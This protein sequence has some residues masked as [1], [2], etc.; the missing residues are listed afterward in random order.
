MSKKFTQMCFSY[1]VDVQRFHDTLY[2]VCFFS[3]SYL[4]CSTLIILTLLRPSEGPRY[5]HVY[6]WKIWKFRA[7]GCGWMETAQV[8][9]HES[10]RPGQMEVRQ[11]I[12]TD[13]PCMTHE[14][15]KSKDTKSVN[16]S[17]KSN[18][19][20]AFPWFFWG[21]FLV[22][23]SQLNSQLQAEML[24][25]V[26]SLLELKRTLLLLATGSGKSLCY[27]LPAYLCLGCHAAFSKWLDDTWDPV[28]YVWRFF[29]SHSLSS[30]RAQQRLW[31]VTLRY[32]QTKNSSIDSFTYMWL[33]NKDPGLLLCHVGGFHGQILTRKL[34]EP[35]A[36]STLRL[37]EEGLTLVVSPLVSLM[38]DQ[39][40]RLPKCLFLGLSRIG[41]WETFLAWRGKFNLFCV[42]YI[43]TRK[44][45][46]SPTL[47][48]TPYAL[49]CPFCLAKFWLLD[50]FFLH[51]LSHRVLLYI[52][53][54]DTYP[55]LM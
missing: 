8:F 47:K 35:E 25:A 45:G 41:S 26:L 11:N 50:S 44:P 55:N 9:G 12:W 2:E 7:F 34:D 24:Q 4:I 13:G 1:F 3:A 39:L 22:D 38:Q 51:F 52:L 15:E 5:S 43:Y 27:Q 14:F 31:L 33:E 18:C 36:R 30:S 46:R 49:S 54:T 23:K 29:V 17:D 6:P 48:R 10:F 21:Y 40:A 53:E 20:S 37:R 16:F 32:L 19:I 42:I 28:N